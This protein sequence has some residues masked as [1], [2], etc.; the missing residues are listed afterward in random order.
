MREEVFG[1]VQ[2]IIMVFTSS[3]TIILVLKFRCLD[4]NGSLKEKKSEA[5]LQRGILPLSYFRPAL[6][7]FRSHPLQIGEWKSLACSLIYFKA[8]A[9]TQ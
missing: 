3:L 2:E 8:S 1:V 9:I 7:G 4:G 6:Q 5:S